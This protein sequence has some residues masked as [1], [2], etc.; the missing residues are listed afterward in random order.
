M[1]ENTTVSVLK[2][3]AVAV[4]TIAGSVAAGLTAG[5]FITTIFEKIGKRN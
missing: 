2:T 4:V 1:T 3:L 5:A